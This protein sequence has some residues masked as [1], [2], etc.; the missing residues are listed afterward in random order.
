MTHLGTRRSA[1]KTLAGLAAITVGLTVVVTPTAQAAQLN[2]VAG[3]Q[4]YLAMGDSVGYA[5]GIDFYNELR[6]FNPTLGFQ[7]F[8]CGGE[9]SYGFQ[10]AD[11]SAAWAACKLPGAQ[12]YSAAIAG[13]RSQL[14]AALA[15]IANHPGKIAGIS[16]NIGGNDADTSVMGARIT[17]A[18]AKLRSAVG[19]SV[20]IV[21]LTRYNPGVAAWLRGTEAERDNARAYQ[22]QQTQWS[23]ESP[24]WYMA[25]G[26]SQVVDV[27]AVLGLDIPLPAK[28]K[29]VPATPPPAAANAC[30]YTRVCE[31]DLHL[32]QAGDE[33][34]APAVATALFGADKKV[35]PLPVAAVTSA[36]AQ[37]TGLTVRRRDTAVELKW[38]RR[39]AGT[40]EVNGYRVDYTSDGT[41]HTAIA[42]TGWGSI[43]QTVTGLANGVSYRFRITA[44]NSVGQSD[45]S[46]VSEVATPVPALSA[47]TNLVAVPINRG[48]ELTWNPPQSDGGSPVT[49][50][51]SEVSTDGGKTWRTLYEKQDAKNRVTIQNL[52]NGTSYQIR[53]RA[54]TADEMGDASNVVTVV[55]AVTAPS[56][57]KS[58][59]FTPGD[60]VVDLTWSA[61]ESDGGKPITSHRIEIGPELDGQRQWSVAIADTATAAR[62]ARLT[63]LINGLTY[64]VRISAINQVGVGK[65]EES[66][67]FRPVHPMSDKPSVPQNVVALP[68]DNSVTLAWQEPATDS[69][70]K[71][72]SYRIE[73]KVRGGSWTQ[74][75]EATKSTDRSFTV[76][77]LANGTPVQFR[78]GARNF[79]G[80]S[81]WATTPEVTPSAALP[82][83]TPNTAGDVIANKALLRATVS[84]GDRDAAV[85]FEL[86]R[87][88]DLS[89]AL[90]LPAREGAVA[91]GNAH[92]R[93]VSARDLVPGAT[94][95]FR[96]VATS[97]AGT[98][99][100]PVV[101][102]TTRSV[103]LSVTRTALSVKANSAT[104][105]GYSA[106]NGVEVSDIWFTVGRDPQLAD[107]VRVDPIEPA[108]GGTSNQ[109][110]TAAL[111]GLSPATT[112]YVRLDAAN[113]LGA[114]NGEIVSFTTSLR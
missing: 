95:Y 79:K 21:G 19:D 82:V 18:V 111:A 7:S 114:G 68:A 91:A 3:T 23:T 66:T 112:Y 1:R 13:T 84:A 48:A 49:N 107:G 35:K 98:T 81:L 104:V 42:D 92:E 88:A 110:Y 22:A 77:G 60:G 6:R 46:A 28:G 67:S 59:V 40:A 45:P 54:I 93:S 25:G 53:M 83:V 99:R 62:S 58:I 17:S 12:E 106:S 30:V 96:A 71:I 64:R 90:L 41:W 39:A 37:P 26:A 4:Y 56:N 10:T 69:N 87:N 52:V 24:P 11:A 51:R 50:H 55:P 32:S 70:A 109:N 108:K 105:R 9:N 94:Y 97:A 2:S 101:A 15:F 20:P 65:Y 43:Q 113:S 8:A 103:P 63:G 78:I 44:L 80:L 36:P 5:S 16:L 76:T 29:P 86:G 89:G 75:A 102:F 38:D 14:D 31:G 34:L 33:R 74:V 72:T 61:P 100:G 73:S 57:P 47:P 27:P 85:S